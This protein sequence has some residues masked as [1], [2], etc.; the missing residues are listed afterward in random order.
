MIDGR[1]GPT[2]GAGNRRVISPIVHPMPKTTAG[3]A[4]AKILLSD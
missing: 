3:K 4:P 2:S 1:N